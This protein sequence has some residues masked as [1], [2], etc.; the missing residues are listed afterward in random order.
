MTCSKKLQAFPNFNLLFLYPTPPHKKKSEIFCRI[1]PMQMKNKNYKKM[2]KTIIILINI[3][4]VCTHPPPPSHPIPHKITSIPRLSIRS[5]QPY[6]K[7]EFFN[8]AVTSIRLLCCTLQGF[9]AA[10]RF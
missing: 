6:F 4:N 7:P 8:S 2:F 5:F 10:K 1:L 9:S 3:Q